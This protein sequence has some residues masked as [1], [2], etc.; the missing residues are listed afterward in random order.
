MAGSGEYGDEPLGFG[1]AE[2]VTND[3]E[4]YAW[5]LL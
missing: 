3:W 5:I 2:L 1:A 4:E